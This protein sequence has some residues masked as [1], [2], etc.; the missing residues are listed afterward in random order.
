MNFLII[1]ALAILIT[2]ESSMNIQLTEAEQAELR[3]RAYPPFGT[4][5]SIAAYWRSIYQARGIQVPAGKLPVT[6]ANGQAGHFTLA[7]HAKA[8]GP[9]AIAAGKSFRALHEQ[10]DREFAERLRAQGRA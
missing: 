8:L 1:S 4:A 2:V 3:S 9:Q 7:F 6:T 5:P 10:K